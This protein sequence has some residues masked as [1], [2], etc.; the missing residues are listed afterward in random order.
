MNRLFLCLCIL[1]IGVS[2]HAQDEIPVVPQD[3]IPPAITLAD[4]SADRPGVVR[5]NNKGTSVK[6]RNTKRI[7]LGSSVRVENIKTGT[8]AADKTNMYF[9]QL[10]AIFNSQGNVR[11]FKK[12]GVFGN[13]YK[14]FVGNA[15]KIKL[16]YFQ[17]KNEASD[18]LR[19]IKSMG[20]RDAFITEGK[21]NSPDIELAFTGSHYI[22]DATDN[23][24]ATS[25]S[26]SSASYKIRLDSYQ[27]AVWF[28]SAAVDDLGRIEQWTKG[29]WTI[30]VLSAYNSLE[31][32]LRIKNIAI[33]RGFA[34]AEVVLDNN[35]MLEKVN[36]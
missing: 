32:A 9:I 4:V 33:D 14:Q 5:V 3:D 16:G 29:S 19:Q 7:D 26:S 13:I 17:D 23:T 28:S 30:F 12:L 20:Y 27:D 1:F 8:L 10:A 2:I 15:V 36:Y 35:G 25:I 34:N 18:I 22:Q 6:T 24:A 31:E 21:I 11:E